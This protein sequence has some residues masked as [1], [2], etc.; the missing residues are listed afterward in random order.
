MRTVVMDDSHVNVKQ[1][2]YELHGPRKSRRPISLEEA[3]RW[4][5]LDQFSVELENDWRANLHRAKEG[6]PDVASATYHKS[7]DPH[8]FSS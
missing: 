6:L 5:G 3:R 1:V 7:I 2:Q 8:A 4:E